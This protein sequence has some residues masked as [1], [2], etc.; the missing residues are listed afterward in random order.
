MS[1]YV[2]LTRSGIPCIILHRK[3]IRGKGRS[4]SQALY[5]M[6]YED[7]LSKCLIPQYN[8]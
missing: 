4:D 8:R 7:W 5:V 3:V 1:P 2:S 6:V